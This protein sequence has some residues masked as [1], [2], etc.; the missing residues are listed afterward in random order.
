[1]WDKNWLN[2]NRK[3][4]IK[5]QSRTLEWKIT[6]FLNNIRFEYVPAV[7]DRQFFNYLFGKL[8]NF[9]FEKDKSFSHQSDKFN[10]LLKQQTN[11][12]FKEFKENTK[13]DASFTM[14]R[15]LIDFFRTLTVETDW[16]VSLFDRWDWVQARFI[17]DILNEMSKDT[18]KKIIWWFEEPENSY[19]SKNIRKLRDDFLN[20]Y[21]ES[22]QIFITTHSWEFLS[23]DDQNTSIYRVFKG[24]NDTSRI[25]RFNEENNEWENMCDDL[26]IVLESRLIEK[27]QIRLTEQEE[28]IQKSDISVEDQKQITE[29]MIKQFDNCMDKLKIVENEIALIRKPNIFF[30]DKYL[31]I[32]KIAWL[33]INWISFTQDDLEQ[34]FLNN[35]PY[36]FVSKDWDINL[37][38]FLDNPLISE[39]DK[40]KIVGVFDFDR[41]FNQFN[42]LNK[43]RWDVI[44]GTE[45]DW[46]YRVR[47]GNDKFQ[48]ML[49]PVPSHRCNYA[50]IE[51]WD[52]SKL[53]IE[54]YFT[55]ELLLKLWCLDEKLV[56]WVPIP[57]KVF[58]WEKSE[59]W[60]KLINLPKEE[61]ESF[62][63]LFSKIDA[64]LC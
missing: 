36:N 45:I 6:Q 22:K 9:L 49:L 60:K 43:D 63:L 41:A 17:P 27:L 24:E 46:L 2:W 58:W 13:I 11:N 37:K 59:F 20:K 39:W 28:V 3:H 23:I 15:T 25:V 8:Q 44:Q 30:E 19:E 4:G 56:A 32:Y 21:S 18:K 16:W 54:L 31:E 7:K 42:W 34:V 38:S 35:C 10:E 12:L 40:R 51:L 57:V 26:W 48:A 50:S 14:P 5:S 53:T 1:M 61:F 55:D 33:K 64:L 29:K 47:K 52:S 62:R